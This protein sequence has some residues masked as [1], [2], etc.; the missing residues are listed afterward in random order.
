MDGRWPVG[1]IPEV[2][3]KREGQWYRAGEWEGLGGLK[4][5]VRRQERRVRGS[6]QM[7]MSQGLG[8]GVLSQGG[9]SGSDSCAGVDLEL[10]WGLPS[11]F[12]STPRIAT[13]FRPD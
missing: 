12:T 7:A 6:D 10:Q 1:F 4:G 5:Y 11:H 8:I 13:I 9:R 3:K 2:D